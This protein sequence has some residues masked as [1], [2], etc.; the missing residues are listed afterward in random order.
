MS[1]G[2]AY[3]TPG[4]YR[5]A[6]DKE[7]SSDDEDIGR[8]LTAISRFLDV[9]LRRFFTQDESVVTRDPFDGNGKTRLRLP[10][11]IASSTGL[12]VKVDLDGDF[13]YE[14]TLTLGTHFWLGPANADKGPEAFP[15]EF[16]DIVPTN[17]VISS[18][19]DQVRAVEI[20]ALFGWPAVPALLTDLTI[21][22][23]RQFADGQQ[24]GAPLE[25]QEIDDVVRQSD[26]L[27]RLLRDAQ[28]VYA[29]PQGT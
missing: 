17:T 22:I 12:I 1:I 14:Q 4:Q 26:K 6:I 29:R 18:W 10:V 13:A 16:L 9:R 27:T 23:V 24:S 11:D 28:R 7:D 19:P 20:A 3:A 8:K 5:K 25:L 2:D 15:W 21:S